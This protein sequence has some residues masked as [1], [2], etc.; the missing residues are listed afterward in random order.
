MQSFISNIQ[1]SSKLI[2]VSV[3]STIG[4]AIIA[5]MNLWMANIGEESLKTV[6]DK[7]II[8][9]QKVQNAA[10]NFENILK[11]LISA[12]SIFLPTGQAIDKLNIIE[13]EMDGFFLYLVK[14]S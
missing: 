9:T 7:T 10:D 12:S 6:Y 8:P 4:V 13:K 2:A 11:D 1:I 5:L 14:I 3:V